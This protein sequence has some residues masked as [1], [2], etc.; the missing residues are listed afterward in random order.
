MKLGLILL[1]LTPFSL[2]A[3]YRVYQYSI[4]TT[5]PQKDDT[6]SYTVVSTLDPVSYRSYHGGSQS[7]QINLIRTW[8]C[9]GHTGHGQYLCDSPES[10]AS[11]ISSL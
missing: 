9:M 4:R 1:L 3:E 11:E 7:I 2:L 10:Q 6:D 5:I 8:M